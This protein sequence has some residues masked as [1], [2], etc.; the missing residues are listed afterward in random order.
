MYWEYLRL[1]SLF[2]GTKLPWDQQWLIES[3]SDSTIYNA[4][5]TV[6]HFIQGGTFRGN[7]ENMLKIKP[8]QMTPE[9]W[10]YIFFK[11]APFPKNCK[12]SKESLD[13]MKKSFQ[14]W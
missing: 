7:K 11:D 6:A 9:V 13:K 12:I 4:Y 5:Y 2:L 1:N 8:E 10:D 14:F 3:L